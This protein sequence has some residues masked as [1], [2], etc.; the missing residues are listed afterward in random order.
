MARWTHWDPGLQHAWLHACFAMCSGLE[1]G[2]GIMMNCTL[3]EIHLLTPI[4]GLL[5]L[6]DARILLSHIITACQ[7]P[8]RELVMR[9][10]YTCSVQFCWSKHWT[11]CSSQQHCLDMQTRTDE[12]WLRAE[13]CAAASVA[14]VQP[15]ADVC[16][17]RAGCSAA[18]SSSCP[19]LACLVT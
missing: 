12:V 8:L 9:R 16:L 17:N 18:V 19:W 4:C 3:Q 7:Q 1:Q 13:A 14:A 6:V 15:F 10:T 11:G 5:L 2:L